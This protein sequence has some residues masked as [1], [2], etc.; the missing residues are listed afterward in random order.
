MLASTLDNMPK[1]FLAWTAFRTNKSIA[2]YI[3]DC[4]NHLTILKLYTNTFPT[5]VPSGNSFKLIQ[6]IYFLVSALIDHS[7]NFLIGLLHNIGI[8]PAI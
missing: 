6:D 7:P 4:I 1:I 2:C 8:Y 3:G 5:I